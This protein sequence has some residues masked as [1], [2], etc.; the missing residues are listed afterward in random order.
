MQVN[1]TTDSMKRGEFLR[2]L[3]L[4]TAALMSFYCLGTTLTACSGSSVDPTPAIDTTNFTLDLTSSSTS[5]LKTEGGYIYQ[6]TVIVARVTG[7]GYVALS[8]ACTHE[9]T[10]V[11]YRLTQNDFY[12]SNHGSEFSTSGLVQV[13]PATK[14]LTVYKTTLSAGGNSLQ[15][16]LTS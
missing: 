11:Q 6:D 2:S 7:G 14:S 15:V 13:G 1:P 8:K 9:G 12:C 4:S 5:S 3:G 16:S 10:N